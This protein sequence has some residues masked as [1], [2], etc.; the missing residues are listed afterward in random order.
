MAELFHQF[1]TVIRTFLPV[2]LLVAMVSAAARGRRSPIGTAACGG[3]AD[4]VLT[5]FGLIIGYLVF[6]PQ[7]Q[8]PSA[9]ALRPGDDLLLA[10]Q[11]SPGNLLP[12]AELVGNGIL[13]LPLGVLMPLRV[14]SLDTVLKV[15]LAGL[16]TSCAI[17][18][19]QY[20][21]ITGRTS[22]ADDVILNTLGA[23]FGGALSRPL[24]RFGAPFAP[25][26][27]PRYQ[28]RHAAPKRVPSTAGAPSLRRHAA[29]QARHYRYS[30]GIG[31]P[32][33]PRWQVEV[34]DG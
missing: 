13:L 5:Y 33:R 29:T 20:F 12:W 7:P 14:R 26:R 4:G 15:M 9:L 21:A 3:A 16:A 10:L 31:S 27:R 28:P 32:H 19:I 8:S 25:A 34:G 1:L 18:L 2:A 23:T 17:E 6:S 22:S 11:A 24:V 30:P